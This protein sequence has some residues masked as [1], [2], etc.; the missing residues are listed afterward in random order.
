MREVL[1][2]GEPFHGEAINYRK[3]GSTYVVEWLVTP[4]RAADGR[5]V[6]WVSAQRDVT[7]R[8]AAE[9]RRALL[10]RECIIA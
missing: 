4:V 1:Q 6:R 9:D 2:A 7:E 3:D 10:V 8:R 5:V